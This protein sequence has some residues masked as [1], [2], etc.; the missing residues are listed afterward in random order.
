MIKLIN[1]IVN[2]ITEDLIEIRRHLH[3]IPE[4]ENEEFKTSAYIKA[5]LDELG[6]E[7]SKLLD[8]GIVAL[9]RGEKSE[10]KTI[11]V[12]ADIDALPMNENND[13]PFKSVHDGRMHAC[14]HDVHITC[15]LGMCMVL[16]E[17][18]S[19]FCGNVKI[20]FQPAEEGLGSALRMIE[21]GVM[22]NPHVDACV[23]LHVEPMCDVGTIQF[24]NGA[25]MASPDDF[26]IEIKGKGGHGA[27]PEECI[28]PIYA[29]S[30][31][32]SALENIVSN[33]QNELSKCVVS[34][35]T[36]DAGDANNIIPE[37]AKI[38]GT[39]RSL[40][41][42]TRDNAEK[43]LY[44]YTEKICNGNNCS[45]EFNFNRLYPPVINDET[46]NELL[47]K[48]VKLTTGMNK[49]IELEKSSMTGDDFSYFAQLVPSTYFKLGACNDKTRCVL[50]SPDFD[51]DE[52][53]IPLGAELLT[54]I[55]LNYLER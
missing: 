53:C 19:N 34:V 25:I 27:C 14:G 47:K 46:M 41:N 20:V 9:I 12:R 38:G 48:A 2:K 37:T 33:N 17:L 11:L 36:V 8:T 28:N 54:Q 16:N 52:K 3:S 18:K 6:I 21:A 44:E 23:A 22:E 40:D 35:C 5:I 29:L 31:L 55:V 50:H 15:A 10:G 13:L 30:K 39:V 45:F 24:R 43:I 42:Q 7:N 4:L 49:I 1:K 51:I 26:E 32:V